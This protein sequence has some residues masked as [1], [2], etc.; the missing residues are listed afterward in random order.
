MRRSTAPTPS[1]T[2]A[3]AAAVSGG[4][5]GP[6]RRGPRGLSAANNGGLLPGGL[7]I[8]LVLVNV[9]R[10][11]EMLGNSLGGLPLGKITLVLGGLTIALRPALHRQLR[12]FELPQGRAFL[13]LSVAVCLSVPFSLYRSASLLVARDFLI[14]NLATVVL[15]VCFVR[16]PADLERLMKAFSVSVLVIGLVMIS[17]GGSTGVDNGTQRMYI[18]GTYD[19][20]DVALV[21]AVSLPGS[22][23]LLRN[24]SRMWK[25]LG[26]IASVMA[27]VITV[28]TVSR[29]GVIAVA[30][31]VLAVTFSGRSAFPKLLR[32]LLIPV[33]AVALVFA[34]E[35][36]TAR[37][38][39][40]WRPSE[41]YNVTARSG[42]LQI[43]ERGFSYMADRPLTGVGVGQFGTAEGGWA[44]SNGLEEGFKWSAPHNMYVEVGAELGF[45][46]L[47]AFVWTLFP[48]LTHPRTIARR[49]HD[50][51]DG[52]LQQAATLRLATVAFLVGG[53]FLSAGLSPLAMFLATCG[54]I[55]SRF[56]REL[57]PN[58][59]HPQEHGQRCTI[60]LESSAA[61]TARP[62]IH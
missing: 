41:D 26:M 55:V 49:S 45:L 53:T 51:D 54:I 39:T 8:V 50:M 16:Q 21:A 14:A 33:L 28:L 58:T 11:H 60:A 29:G 20:N 12:A 24:R 4:S 5:R 47:L 57:I 2:G 42:R 38:E 62:G 13:F 48:N 36:F 7:A 19:P 44:E 37:V 32:V 22:L 40:L 27:I 23:T 17:G 18:A 25:L 3:L 31:T 61:R 35:N 15:I 52:L 56:S 6:R 34:P 1:S 46:G 9:G 30:V 10:L 43:W 59:N